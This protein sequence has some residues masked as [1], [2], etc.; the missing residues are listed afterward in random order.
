MGPVYVGR[1][2][3]VTLGGGEFVQVSPSSL[4]VIDGVGL[5]LGHNRREIEAGIVFARP[6][7]RRARVLETVW[8]R[9]KRTSGDLWFHHLPAASVVLDG[10]D[11]GGRP[12][13]WIRSVGSEACGGEEAFVCN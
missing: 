7:G 3:A 8:Y 1:L 6:K 2:W 4:G 13:V 10:D 12:Y 5:V 9:R 11:A